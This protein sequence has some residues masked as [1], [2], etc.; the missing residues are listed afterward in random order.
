MTP[1]GVMFLFFLAALLCAC[2]LKSNT[3]CPCKKALLNKRTPYPAAPAASVR[4]AQLLAVSGPDA[5]LVIHALQ[6]RQDVSQVK[7]TSL[8]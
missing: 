4:L 2:M 3:S 1:N 5:N 7:C 8:C 6:H